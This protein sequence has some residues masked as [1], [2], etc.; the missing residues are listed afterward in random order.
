MGAALVGLVVGIVVGLTSMGGGA[1]LT[2]ALIFLGIPASTAIGSDVLIASVTKFFGSGAYVLK[3]EIHW[4]TVGSLAL[5]SIPGALVG[6]RVLNAIPR[7]SVDS[8]VVYGLGFVLL[9]AGSATLYRLTLKALP[10]THPMPGTATIALMGFLTGFIVMVTSVGSGSLLMVM[11]LRFVP[12]PTRRLVGTDIVHALILSS[13]ATFLH[14]RSGRVDVALALSVLVGA[15]P[16]VLLGARMA[17]VL[18]EKG[19]RG[20]VAG[21]LVFVGVVLVA[22]GP[23]HPKTMI[24]APVIAAEMH[25]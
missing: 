5:G 18:P 21:I 22:K 10:L 9:I 24:A 11:M 14:A 15:I 8:F 23:T 20:A 7:A 25:H 13:L 17:G 1:L 3:R 2:P 6:N 12:L 4:R 19:L 16:G